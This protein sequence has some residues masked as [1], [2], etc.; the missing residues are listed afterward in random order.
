MTNTRASWFY[1]GLFLL[2]MSVLMLQIT[3]TRIL[4][5]VAYYYLA[6]LTISM[7]MFGMTAGALLVYFNQETFDAKRLSHHLT[8]MVSAYAIALVISFLLQMAAVFTVKPVA[9]TVIIWAYA[10]LLLSVPYVFA[11]M[12]V[13][14]AL[15]RSPFRIG[16]V[17]GVDLIGAASGC[18]VVLVLL[19]T[20]D[21]PSAM[22]AIAA[23]AAAAAF[24]FSRAGVD[25]APEQSGWYW[26]V[27]KRPRLLTAIILALGVLNA[28]TPYGIRPVVV[29]N[30]LETPQDFAFEK[31]NSFSRIVAYPSAEGPPTLWSPSP[32]LDRNVR[33]EE[34]GLNIDGL[35]GTFMPRFNGDL[36]SVS[37][38]A[39]DV[40]NLAYYIRN[41]G[42]SAVV[43]VGS[44]R[45]L[46]SA[47]LFGFRDVIGVELN[48]IF[49]GLL[50]N[51]NELRDYA[52]IAD[53]PGI[54]LA[55][56]EGRSWFARTQE[57]FNLIQMSM[58]DTFASTGA[59]AFSLSENGLYTV[60][61]WNIF[62]SAL[63]P[64]GVFTVSRWHSPQSPVEIGR[65]VSLAL[66][67][68]FSRGAQD[69]KSHIFLVSN[70]PLATIVVGRNPLSASDVQG[71]TEA[72]AKL[73]YT[74][75]MS[76]GR[77]IALP[78]F[79]DLAG[80]TGPDD[81]EARAQRYPLDISAP[82]DAR[83]F[84]FN[85]LRMTHP[86]DWMEMV[87]E[88]RRSGSFHS[89]ASL[90]AAGNL[91][92]IGTLFLLIVLS[93]ILVVAV[94]VMPGRSSVQVADRS[95]VWSGTA[96]FLLIGIGFML[97]EI[98]LIQRMS[99]FIGHPVYALS[100]VLFS[101]ILATGIGSFLSERLVLATKTHFAI[102][103]GASG[104]Y[105]LSLPYWLPG[106][107]HTMEAAALLG[108]AAVSVAVI[109]PPG[110]LMGF[111]FPTGMRLATR[112]DPRPT[113]WFWGINGAAGVLAAGI[114]VMT[115]IAFSIN[116]TM[117]LGGL[118]YLLLY[119]ASILLLPHKEP[120][121]ISAR[122]ASMNPGVLDPSS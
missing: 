106:L 24:C 96:Y 64:N 72:A 21:T 116:T 110:I 113:P 41:R 23:I 105:L 58:I 68:L 76:P 25:P 8:W 17:Y 44:G 13:S 35:A 120:E 27:L 70:G 32:A 100:I 18:L 34:R 78:V 1:P 39:Y 31:W 103:L 65:V 67:A 49:V 112:R 82:T 75:L 15:T 4:S 93:A 95:L 2:C 81:L 55:V 10:L 117:Q 122:P 90:V 26:R 37:F 36:E 118:C 85:Q 107:T 94:I 52:G 89:G 19:N 87:A 7:A 108:R 77:P 46:L 60:E 40:T 63:E 62:L 12:A 83:P 111:A 53:L 61:A 80:A 91:L 97:V 101:I 99:I 3:E 56:E 28:S 121:G 14:L 102:W 98:G 38:L 57:R 51:R 6:F 11:G 5:V 88:Y 74:V 59:G 16:L 29:K 22:F 109:V 84:F 33:V 104:L 71:L 79:R 20:V 86:R 73:R 9:T 45:D 54:R 43:G 30:A 47:Y 114:G 48:P 119:P 42:K 66:A 69:P 50:Q 115:N 92:A